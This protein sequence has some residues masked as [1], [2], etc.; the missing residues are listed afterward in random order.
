MTEITK[1]RVIKNSKGIA[2]FNIFGIWYLAI[3]GKFYSHE[4]VIERDI[5]LFISFNLGKEINWIVVCKEL[6]EEARYIN[7]YNS[8]GN[9]RWNIFFN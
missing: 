8:L 7:A 4:K 5:E 1:A 6:T 9:G 3:K 2:V